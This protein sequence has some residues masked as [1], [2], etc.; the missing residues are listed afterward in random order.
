MTTENDT[1][2]VAFTLSVKGYESILLYY[3]PLESLSRAFFSLPMRYRH[4]GQFSAGHRRTSALL[5]TQ[6]SRHLSRIAL[7]LVILSSI[8]SSVFIST[9]DSKHPYK[10]MVNLRSAASLRRY[11]VDCS[12]YSS[13]HKRSILPFAGFM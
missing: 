13:T 2:L 11:T 9:Y 6:Q 8:H 4:S 7:P 1:M 5:P 10:A 3:S 12:V